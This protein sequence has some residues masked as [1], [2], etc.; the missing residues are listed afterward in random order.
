M[1]SEKQIAAN[2]ANAQKSTGPKTASGKQQSARNALKHGLL[3]KDL[4]LFD[5]SKEDYEQLL[6]GLIESHQPA[7][8]SEALLVEKMAIALWKMRRLNAVETATIHFHQIACPPL[9]GFARYSEDAQAM[10]REFQ[11]QMQALPF[12][13]QRLVRYHAQLEGQYYRALTALQSSQR[14]RSVEAIPLQTEHRSSE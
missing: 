14:H 13:D 10:M 6:N 5:E 12:T 4:L 7:N 3:S 11:S 2:R 1:P 9:T 8:L